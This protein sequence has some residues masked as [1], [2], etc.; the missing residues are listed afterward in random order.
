MRRMMDAWMIAGLVIA[1]LALGAA[2]AAAGEGVIIKAEQKVAFMGDSITQAGWGSKTGYVRLVVSGLEANGVN[3]VPVP[4]GISG[5]KSNQML[6]RLDRDV[7]SK[8][9]DWM[10]LSCGVNDVW[11]GAR[12]VPLE[13]YRK[14]IT[15]V[16][17]KCQAAGVEV[18]ILTA[19]MIGEE[20]DNANNKKLKPYNDFLHELAK[21]KK[22]LLA[23]LNAD[24]QADLA[25][26]EQAGK[27]RGRLLTSDGVHMNVMGDQVM[28]RGIL[29]TFGLG[30]EHLQ[31]AQEAWADIPDAVKVDATCRMSLRQYQA[32]E[33]AAA[34]QKKPVRKLCDEILSKGLETLV[35]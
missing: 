5:H 26:S 1:A 13:Q 30:D 34:S 19:T 4:A 9:P 35:K 28:A 22:C 12:G 14:N 11:H 8:K 20:A 15:E 32:L 17:D 29:R 18:M 16:V 10:T 23:D 31:K 25:K 21:E 33:A 6:A 3:V 24:M 7:L 27:K 2:P